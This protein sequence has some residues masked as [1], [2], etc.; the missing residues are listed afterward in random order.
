MTGDETL[1]A[2][3]RMNERTDGAGASAR[4]RGRTT[5]GRCLAATAAALLISGCAT[6]IGSQQKPLTTSSVGVDKDAAPKPDRKQQPVKIAMLLPLGGV[7][8]SSAVAKAMKQAGEMA[9]F[10]LDN[11]AIQ[12]N[13]KD[14]GGT[15]ETARAAA[16]QAIK[17][18]A[19]IIL[20]PLFSKS[21][22]GAA[23]AARAANVPVLAFSNDRQAAGNGVHLVSFM[24]EAEVERV[25]AFA[26]QNGKKRF[27]A[28][29][30]DD[31]YGRVVEP[32][33]R[34]AVQKAGGSVASVELYAT[35]ANAMIEPARRAVEAVK[36]GEASGSPVD[37]LFVPG[38]P[39]VLP[40]L[41]PL[42]TYSGLDTTKVKLVGTGTWNYP[43]IGRDDAFV[44]GW[45][46]SPDPRGFADFSE[47]FTKTFGQTPPRIASLAYDAVG[48]AVALSSY[49]PGSRFTP[50]NL[51]R[52][53][54]FTGVDGTIK[55]TAAGIP[56][57][58]LAVLE[59]QKFGT[60]VVDPAPSA[61]GAAT[62]LSQAAPA[63]PTP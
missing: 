36:A 60:N 50:T 49:A 10:E 25:V 30:P 59:V 43:N 45:F 5:A 41:G 18:G 63:R 9:L 6:N 27:V 22:G 7:G 54:G 38:G 26:A 44:G 14:D 11:P 48:I 2:G 29:I 58:S 46:P 20:G 53:G 37:A 21:V 12:L 31:A 34:A 42:I 51:T 39:D 32:A 47:R 17:E 1:M 35:Q 56:E 33:F 13:V 19:E 55:L 61:M 40:Q 52:P 57:R 23:Q 8:P 62:R 28:L 16:D 15:P 4:R 24:A 3:K